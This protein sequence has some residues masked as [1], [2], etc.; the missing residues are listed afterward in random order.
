MNVFHIETSQ[1]QSVRSL[2]FT[3]ATLF[4]DNGS[5]DSTLSFTIRSQAIIGE[6]TGKVLAVLKFQRL[7][8]IVFET[9]ACRIKS[10]AKR[11]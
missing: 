8:L 7:H 11:S 3:L 9:V 6:L 10:E 4:T 1:I 5:T 2:T